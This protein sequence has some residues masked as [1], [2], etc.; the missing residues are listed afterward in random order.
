MNKTTISKLFSIFVSAALL[1]S[2]WS[3]MAHA[4]LDAPKVPEFVRDLTPPVKLGYVESH[5]EGSADTKPVVLIMDLHAN[6]GVQ[7]NIIAIL[8]DLQPKVT[9][10]GRSMVL[11]IEAAWGEVDLAPIRQEK[12]EVRELVGEFFLKEA[13][14]TGMEHFAA[15]SEAPVKLVGID[16]Q[17]DYLLHRD[18]FRQSLSARLGLGHKVEKMRKAVAESKKHAPWSYFD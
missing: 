17:A 16:D 15:M 8:K 10:S 13:E 4:I 3:G 2:S 7:K 12:P 6:L 1:S 14:I 18:L 9:P 11:G 5:F